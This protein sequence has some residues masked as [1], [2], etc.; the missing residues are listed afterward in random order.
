[1]KTV[2]GNSAFSHKLP[3]VDRAVESKAYD[4]LHY[5]R[6]A[7]RALEDFK[8]P[9]SEIEITDIHSSQLTT[10]IIKT[11]K[12]WVL[13]HVRQHDIGIDIIN[14]GVVYNLITRDDVGDG[15]IYEWVI[16]TSMKGIIK[17]IFVN[18]DEDETLFSWSVGRESYTLDGMKYQPS[19]GW[20]SELMYQAFYRTAL[21]LVGIASGR[22]VLKNNF[23]FNDVIKLSNELSNIGELDVNA[24][25]N[26]RLMVYSC[27]VNL[28]RNSEDVEVKTTIDA[29]GVQLELK[30]HDACSI[31]V[32][33][34]E[35]GFV[36]VLYRGNTFYF[37]EDV[38]QVRIKKVYDL[39]GNV[40][41]DKVI[42]YDHC[43]KS[44]GNHRQLLS[45]FR[46]AVLSVLLGI[47]A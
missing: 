29:D 13:K 38:C 43:L 39:D 10:K 34:S 15:I 4:F 11:A 12:G 40:I 8:T 7:Q 36:E 6:E 27:L 32:P 9:P 20:L 47:P 1:M 37:S 17:D 46:Q 16:Y 5:V 19:N 33:L 30:L 35:D 23:D 25:N 31:N 24:I 3:I 26:I 22:V 44:F 14:G 42:E 28:A 18:N 45:G 21:A 2:I 41:K